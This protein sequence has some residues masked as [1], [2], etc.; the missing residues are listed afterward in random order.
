MS[1][2]IE[3]PKGLDKLSPEEAKLMEQMRADDEGAA[4]APEPAARA[5]PEPKPEP[6]AEIEIDDAPELDGVRTDMV[7][8]KALHAERVKRQ[9][10]EKE[11][12]ALRERTAAETAK[13]QE[14]VNL[15][16]NVAQAASAPPAA[17]PVAEEPLPDVNSDPVGHF[18]AVAD[19]QA[20]ELGDLRAI[21]GGFQQQQQQAAQARELQNWGRNQEAAFAAREPTY[22]QAMTHLTQ[23]RLAELQALGITDPGQQQQI[24]AQDIHNIAV[25]ARQQGADFAERLYNL[26]VKRGFKAT[27][28]AASIPALDA[29]A[30]EVPSTPAARREAARDNATT[31]GS[32]GAAPPARLSV[33]KIANMND[34]QFE[35]FVKRF[36]GN[37]EALRDLLGH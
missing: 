28:A 31:I 22:P 12:A 2:T 9:A 30:E 20:R 1:A 25:T 32:V 6:V 35:A 33:E 18:K 8:H 21:M 14:R 24:M 7:P 11:A 34:K 16:V 36:E 13:L 17:A 37:P 3:V 15:L 29:D 26:A 5:T 27:P 23:A 10:A 4:P 19:R